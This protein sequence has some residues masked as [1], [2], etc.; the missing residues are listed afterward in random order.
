LVSISLWAPGS[1][2][3]E[4]DTHDAITGAAFAQ[5][6]LSK[7]YLEQ[8]LASS[9]E[10]SFRASDGQVL[11]ARDWLGAAGVDRI[12]VA[13]AAQTIARARNSIAWFPIEM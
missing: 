5:S 10:N 12:E 6:V 9:I 4:T 11:K 2:A 1:L 7:G 8:Q 3:Y 13:T